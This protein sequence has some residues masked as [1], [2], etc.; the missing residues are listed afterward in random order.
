MTS[1]GA[2]GNGP[3]TASMKRSPLVKTAKERFTKCR[4]LCE[5]GILAVTQP[6]IFS[7][8]VEL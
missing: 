5:G 1:M 2:I 7:I 4:N 3:G 8:L 6:S